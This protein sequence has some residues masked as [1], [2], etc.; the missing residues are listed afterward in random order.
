MNWKKVQLVALER[1]VWIIAIVAYVVFIFLLPALFSDLSNIDFI[2]RCVAAVGVL[3]IAEG[4]CLLSGSVDVSLPAISGF[5]VVFVVWF[6][7]IWFPSPPGFPCLEVAG[8]SAILLLLLVLI[9]GAALGAFNGLLINR[10]GIHSFLITLCTYFMLIGGRQWMAE[11]PGM[12]P[13]VFVDSDIL[14]FL[15]GGKIIGG[16][17]FV[18]VLLLLITFLAWFFLNRSVSG[19]RMYA[20]G[21][22]VTSARLMGVNVKNTRLLVHTLAGII[23]GLGGLVFIGHT[24]LAGV[25]STTPE[26]LDLRLFM[27][28]AMAIFGGI[29]IE[30]GRGNIEDVIAGI[31]FIGTV[32]I[33]TSFLGINVYLRECL[34]GIFILVGI[35]VNS[36]RFKMIDRL[37]MPS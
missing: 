3:A 1:L 36:I 35:I 31:F 33:G 19:L 26:M 22:N 11:L 9:V 13:S 30:G 29:A 15:G 24:G 2:F 12:S 23:A 32:E 17:S 28:F 14:C 27:I 16:Y 34:V 25:G 7:K 20:I 5:A 37:L 21:G 18:M 4:I 10:T 6:G 8:V